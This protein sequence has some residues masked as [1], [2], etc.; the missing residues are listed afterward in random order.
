MFIHYRQTKYP[1]LLCW[2]FGVCAFG[3]A[4]L[5][6]SINVL[7]G[8][9]PAV[10]KI[11][12]M[13]GALIGGFPLAQGAVYLLARRRVADIS[14]ITMLV[15]MAIGAMAIVQTPVDVPENIHE[16]LTGRVFTWEW[17]RFFPLITNSYSF[18]ILIIGGI[19]S[20]YK[21]RSSINDDT[22]Y[23]ANATIALGSLMPGIGGTFMRMGFVNALFV[24]DFLA[25]IVI[26][27]GF[28]ILKKSN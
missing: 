1:Y 23:L 20:A 4:A 16:R 15:I 21:H 6:A 12:Y 3:L 17:V 11:W 24:V 22:P 8:W 28:R 5:A 25:L 27:Y 14:T 26:Y 2:I 13:G 10:L 19:Y 7:V 18:L 9:S